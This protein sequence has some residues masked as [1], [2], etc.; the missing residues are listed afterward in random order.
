MIQRNLVLKGERVELIPME[1]SHAHDL[2][3]A[4]QDDNIWTY[5][6]AKVTTLEQMHDVVEQAIIEREKRTQ[7]P[8]T[9]K[10]LKTNKIV[11]ST[12]Y[13]VLSPENKSLEIGSTWLNSSVWRTRVNTESKYLLLKHCFETLD[14][15]RVEIKTDARNQR[16]Q[17]AIARLGAQ[18]EGTLRKNRILPNGF[19]RDS[20]I[21]SVIAKEWPDVKHRLE[22][23]LHR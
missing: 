15:N 22:G 14:L 6:P 1:T 20:V 23:F 13:L 7:Y 5:L 16:S 3:E 11:G 17:Q 9:I 19:V 8:F 10:D 4:S 2:F 12:R 18:K 21:F